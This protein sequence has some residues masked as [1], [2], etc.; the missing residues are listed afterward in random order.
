MISCIILPTTAIH[1]SSIMAP[2]DEGAEKAREKQGAC[3]L[4]EMDDLN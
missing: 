2:I 3:T 4:P 1:Q